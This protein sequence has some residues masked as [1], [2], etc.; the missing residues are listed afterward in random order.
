MVVP[1]SSCLPLLIAKDTFIHISCI[2][3]APMATIQAIFQLRYSQLQRLEF[4]HSNIKSIKAS[5][6]FLN[7]T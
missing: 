6:N 1:S 2:V 4:C 7:S 5:L 3:H